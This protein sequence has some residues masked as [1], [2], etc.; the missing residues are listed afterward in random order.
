VFDAARRFL[1]KLDILIDNAGLAASGIGQMDEDDWRYVVETNLAGAMACAREAAA[2]M[3]EN[4][5]GQIVIIGSMS[6][7]HKGKDSSVYVTTKSGLRGVCRVAPQ[8]TGRQ[9]YQ[10]HADRTRRGRLGHRRACPHRSNAKQ[11]ESMSF[12]VPRTL[13]SRSSMW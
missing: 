13:P 1:G 8:G 12:S 4:G 9:G 5:D 10:G 2:W 6:A 7:E 11:F 3:R